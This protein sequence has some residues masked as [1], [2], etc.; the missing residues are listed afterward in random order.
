MRS[1]ITAA[2]FSV[3]A[4]GALA[5]VVMPPAVAAETDRPVRAASAHALPG[6]QPGKPLAST[7]RAA[8]P[9][10]TTTATRLASTPT[11]PL[12]VHAATATPADPVRDPVLVAVAPQLS[13]AR[14][15]LVGGIAPSPGHTQPNLDERSGG[16][17]AGAAL[18]L[19]LVVVFR[20][21]GAIRSL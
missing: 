7:D 13:T 15:D 8:A 6:P 10:G 2:W 5:S 21:R 3:A 14:A 19:M 18:L 16:S 4:T 11:S 12:L 17:L 1:V 9:A 20:R